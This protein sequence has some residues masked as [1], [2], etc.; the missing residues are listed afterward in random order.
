MLEIIIIISNIILFGYIIKY[1]FKTNIKLS[2][3]ISFI[4]VWILFLNV[5]PYEYNQN[6]FSILEYIPSQYIP[7]MS[8]LKNTNIHNLQYPVIFKPVKCARNGNN[9]EL[10]NNI[11]EA[12]AYLEKNNNINEIMVQ[13]FVPYKNEVGILYE[14]NIKSIVIKYSKNSAVNDGSCYDGYK[15][16]CKEI[17]HLITPELNNV[18][19]NISN[20][21]P[22]FNVGR[23]DIKYK[24]LNSLLKGTDFYILEVNGT[25]GFDLRKNFLRYFGIEY[26]YYP[27]RWFLYRQLQGLQNIITLK[28]YNPIKLIQIMLLTIH[29]SIGCM[30]WEKLFAIYT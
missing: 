2:I 27:E 25:M 8:M 23:Y 10:I 7:K 26:I 9:V 14:K 1:F 28:G 13:T 5:N 4:I 3:F 29:N 17:S 24:D 15:S 22:N 12:T 16:N 11:S 21:I 20:H 6:K 19:K 18:I 30:D